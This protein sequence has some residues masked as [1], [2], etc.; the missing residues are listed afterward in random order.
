MSPVAWGQSNPPED[1]AA[2]NG[3][4]PIGIDGLFRLGHWTPIRIDG[5]GDGDD[6]WAVETIDG[7]GA[8]IR[9]RGT[10]RLGYAKIGVGGSSVTAIRP[11]AQGAAQGA[12]PDTGGRI[13]W[14][15][16]FS[17]DQDLL[18]RPSP[19]FAGT[20]WVVTLG[21]ALGIDQVGINVVE[22]QP[23]VAV[24]V[25]R[26]SS[27]LPDRSIGYDGVDVVIVTASA[28][29]WIGSVDDAQAGALVDWVRGGGEM[30]WML[31]GEAEALLDRA[32]WLRDLVPVDLDRMERF[33]PAG[34]ETFTASQTPLT[35][36]RG[37]RLPRDRGTV[38]VRGRTTRR[39]VAALAVRY[40]T[41]LGRVTIV[42]AD[43]DAAPFV[44]WPER[45]ELVDRLTDSLLIGGGDQV[46]PPAG[47]SYND[48]GGQ[49]AATLDQPR[50]G[51]GTGFSV[52]AL[53][54]LGLIAL[55]GPLDYWL[56]NRVLGRSQWGWVTFPA[57]VVA[58]SAGLVWRTEATGDQYSHRRVEVLDLVARASDDS[59]AIGSSATGSPASKRPVV[60]RLN[61]VD[62]LQVGRATRASATTTVAPW[63]GDANADWP[64]V[65]PLRYA[66]PA[67]G[68]VRLAVED[69]RLPRYSIDVGGAADG[70]RDSGD[71]IVDRSQVIDL[72][73]PPRSGKS[74]STRFLVRQPRGG[75]QLVASVQRRPGSELLRGGLTNPLPVD[76]LDGQLVYRN[77]AYLLPTRLPAGGRIADLGS[78]RQKNFRWLLTK[79]RA[80]ESS[81]ESEQWASDQTTERIV[82]LMMFHQAAGDTGY[83]RL[84]HD[85]LGE[86]DLSGLLDDDHAVLVGRVRQPA[87]PWGWQ[88]G[89]RDSGAN[90]S[91]PEVLTMVRVV[92]PA[93]L[94]GKN[95]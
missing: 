56:V 23:D 10:G 26:Q 1:P 94:P 15:R 50:G 29:E 6:R 55:V 16:R 91:E 25:V 81:A 18:S 69:D 49:L 28:R 47:V 24:S 22:R 72:P 37:V 13:V 65:S 86:L 89:D 51:A 41:G 74:V 3:S 63:V 66:G 31:G 57:V 9:Y 77:W 71:A 7:D 11:A 79:Q 12:A 43:L 87:S 5:N 19:V 2:V 93:V 36:Y 17:P 33:D 8:P 83:T 78:L 88:L 4:P 52:L 59:L 67:F 73:L 84:S 44:D 46:E 92:M 76:L 75:D 27:A 85:V 48:L 40:V 61:V 21:D 64:I 53:A 42:A 60:G 35:E 14:Q 95:R 32:P 90:A 58:L 70:K 20:P 34:F 39:V 82:N 30:L 45:L 68:G 80:I 62:Q 38:L 54:M